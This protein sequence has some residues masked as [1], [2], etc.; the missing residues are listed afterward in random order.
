[1]GGIGLWENR[2]KIPKGE[3]R[4]LLW[5]ILVFL[6]S[7]H[8]DLCCHVCWEREYLQKPNLKIPVMRP[9][10]FGANSDLGANKEL[11]MTLFHRVT[12]VFLRI[13]PL[14]IVH[15]LQQ[16]RL[17]RTGNRL[18]KEL[19]VWPK[20]WEA[21]LIMRNERNSVCLFYLKQGKERCCNACLQ[22]PTQW[23]NMQ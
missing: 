8:L 1:M 17:R 22:A 14:Y 3:K 18:V 2:Y 21:S 6:R 5:G 11:L 7:E 15:S 23:K 16:I 19:Q 20:I 10:C 9:C 13:R 4:Q 12:F